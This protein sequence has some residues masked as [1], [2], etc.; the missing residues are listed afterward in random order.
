MKG[1]S[2]F[3]IVAILIGIVSLIVMA[4]VYNQVGDSADVSNVN[5]KLCKT[6]IES[7][8]NEIG[9]EGLSE[10][11]MNL[12]SI[13]P[14]EFSRSCPTQTVIIDPNKLD[15]D[16][17][18][19]NLN[20]YDS[21][22]NCVI[23]EIL[24][25][26]RK[27]WDM[28]GEGRLNGYTWS[29]YTISIG[30]EK[31]ID[32]NLAIRNRLK[33]YFDCDDNN[34]NSNCRDLEKESFPNAQLSTIY[35]T[36]IKSKE[37]QDINYLSSCLK[38][39]SEYNSE[40]LIEN[41]DGNLLYNYNLISDYYYEIYDND[42]YGLD[43][44]L[45]TTKEGCDYQEA[46]TK[47]YDLKQK[48]EDLKTK[49]TDQNKI[50]YDNFCLSKIDIDCNNN[51]PKYFELELSLNQ[52]LNSQITSKDIEFVAKTKKY[53]QFLTFSD[54]FRLVDSETDRLSIYNDE[55]LTEKSAFQINYCD[56]LSSVTGGLIPMYMCGTTKKISISNNLDNA[57]K[58]LALENNEASCPILSSLSTIEDNIPIDITVFETLSGVCTNFDIGNV[59]IEE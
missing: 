19:I 38:I 33:S 34:S 25:Y 52:N 23:D 11:V 35:S 22:K 2:T 12:L 10:E 42:L 54:K 26:S 1:Q 45:N 41:N 5:E 27:C 3:V 53:N 8:S 9:E 28:N 56:G 24:D 49:L 14:F 37:N 4:S 32:Q 36:F 48:N 46:R 16:Q 18:V 51:D 13:A 43:L 7:L 6:K 20:P 39:G 47:I 40:I 29:C 15:C 21:T 50:I 59:F 58:R 55:V 44:K 31:E 30:S 17:E 57:G